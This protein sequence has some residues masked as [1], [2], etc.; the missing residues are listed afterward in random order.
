MKL[1]VR[2]DYLAILNTRLRNG[3]VVS[4]QIYHPLVCKRSTLAGILR[5]EFQ[6]FQPS[7]RRLSA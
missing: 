5:L 4:S 2:V 1:I 3:V 6:A 7:F